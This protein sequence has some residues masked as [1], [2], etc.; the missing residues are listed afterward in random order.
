[1]ETPAQQPQK[2][3]G[4]GL[5]QCSACQRTFTR[6]DHL[7]RHVRSHLQERPFQCQTCNKTF[8]R[9]DLLKR[10]AACHE[11]D[12]KTGKR[13]KRQHHQSLRVS[14]ACKPCAT[15]KL[16]CDDEKPCGRCTQ[17]GITCTFEARDSVKLSRSET[18][19]SDNGASPLAPQPSESPIMGIP[20]DSV[21]QVVTMPTPTSMIRHPSVAPL[22]LPSTSP[23]DFPEHHFSGFL[24]GVMTP[25]LADGSCNY[26]PQPWSDSNSGFGNRGL[27]DFTM[28]T[29]FDFDDADFGFIDQLCS[30]PNNV[31]VHPQPMLPH[32]LDA[33]GTETQR[34]HVALG[35][36][37]YKRSSLSIWEPTSKDS[38]AAGLEDLSAL[39]TDQG[40]PEGQPITDQYFI[41]ERLSRLARDKFLGM[42]LNHC[43]L[44]KSHFAIKAFPTAEVL[45]DLLQGFFSHHLHQTDSFVHVPSFRP[46]TLRPE[47]LGGIIAT[48]AVLTDITSVHKLGFAI[49][50]A[51]RTTIPARC[52]ESNAMTRQLW[53]VQAFMCELEIGLWSGVKRKTEIAE[54]HT[55]TLY[56]MLRRGGRFRKPNRVFIPPLLQDTGKVLHN[57]WLEWIEEESYKRLVFHAFI[58]DAQ[59]SMAMFTN[60][61]ISFAELAT[62]LPEARELWLAEDAEQWKTLYLSRPRTQDRNLN[63]VD[64]LRGPI[65]LPEDCDVHL[66]QLVI[67]H[68][69]WGMI[70]QHSQLLSTLRRPGYSDPGL[71]L[72][73]QELIKML[74][75]FRLNISECRDPTPEETT[76]TLELLHMHLHMSFED[77]EYF[78][79]KGDLED[80]R[81]VLP[82]LQ[83]WVDGPESRQAIWH[84]GQVIRAARKFRVKHIR[85]F[86]AIAVYHASLALWAYSI[87]SVAN[88]PPTEVLQNT[89][90]NAVCLDGP[91]TSTVQRFITLG[92]GIPSLTYP[93]ITDT[94]STTLVPLSNQEA[95]ISAILEILEGN[96]PCGLQV[97]AAPPLVENLK[98]LLQDLGR[99]AVSVKS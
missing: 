90:P 39:G 59:T 60:P 64:F 93:Q 47:L 88:A 86:F 9:P 92:K 73:H 74:H 15:A 87:M 45:D 56:T 84:A 97:E 78:A 30:D 57:K 83:E 68:G 67:L 61:V 18:S 35:T 72:R 23:F 44:E 82:T 54:S 91:D 12:E 65:E 55:Q 19:Q 94:T 75:H 24:R 66:L 41:R 34:K 50:E 11:G 38:I 48:G 27:L 22:G 76:L 6:V 69:I 4:Q 10:H 96:F 32:D 7:A 42:I 14:Q 36:E 53:I 62:P 8:G 33:L 80:A 70:W 1:M 16:K 2:S 21:E 31:E 85:G 95:V 63:L 43:R 49:Q 17:R 3:P 28:E 79:G 71:T 99:A 77:I 26:G 13:Q 5:F 89:F 40:S 52:E 20:V 37:A 81:R 29:G 51:V 98:Q 25:H 46:N 58:V